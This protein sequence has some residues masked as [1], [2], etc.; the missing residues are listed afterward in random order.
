MRF[1]DIM[2]IK[3]SGVYLKLYDRNE[4]LVYNSKNPKE[5][6]VGEVLWGDFEPEKESGAI[7][8]GAVTY[9]IPEISDDPVAILEKV[10]EYRKGYNIIHEKLDFEYHD[11]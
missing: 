9:D 11:Y 10:I 7:A 6:L 1:D 2:T 4:V 8:Y 3:Q 5:C